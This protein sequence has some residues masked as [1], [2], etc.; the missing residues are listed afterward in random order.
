MASAY[1]SR[2]VEIQPNLL[3]GLEVEQICGNF[4]VKWIIWNIRIALLDMS[5][6]VRYFKVKYVFF[7]LVGRL[8]KGDN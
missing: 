5:S 1:E 6:R 2:I 7:K 3:E 8:V 4:D